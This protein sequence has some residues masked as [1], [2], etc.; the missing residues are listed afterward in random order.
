MTARVTVG[1]AALCLWALAWGCAGGRPTAAVGELAPDRPLGDSGGL[2]AAVDAK[3]AA[4]RDELIA[5]RRTIHANPEL[6][7]R[8]FQT[9]KLIANYLDKLGLEVKV[10][11]AKTGV[12]ATLKGGR[13]GPL[14]AARADIDA[15]PIT[16]LTP[17]PF[18][19]KVVTVKPGTDLKVGVMHA[20]GHDINTA[21]LL[22]TAAVLASMRD[23]LPG[24]VRFIFQP[25]EEGPPPGEEGG[26]KLMIKEGVLEPGPI[27]IF[28]QHADAEMPVGSLGYTPGPMLA[29][30]DHF[31]VKIVGRGGHGAAPHRTVDPI[32]TAAQAVLALQTIHSRQIDTRYPFVLTVGSI[33]GGTRW[34][35]IPDA[36]VLE[37]TIRTHHESVRKEVH[38]RMRRTLEGIAAAAG[39]TAD[40]VIHDYGPALVNDEALTEKTLPALIRTVGKDK[41]VRRPQT[42]GGEDFAYFA[43]IVPGTYWRLGVRRPEDGPDSFGPTHS[44]RFWPDERSIEI[45]VRAMC[46]VLVDALERGK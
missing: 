38:A 3:A 36:V 17:V 27:A 4:I 2:D 13:P 18:A 7:N 44:A 28:A 16:E 8:E 22:G 19:G 30:V 35:I 23:R 9:A 12:V 26:A 41:V 39:A 45:G 25:A 31:V 40:L 24:T 37:G 42:M 1:S 32:V 6:G 20:C 5:I 33:N 15:L 29:A 11:I 21:C 43:Q 10:G 46:R 14:V 34:N